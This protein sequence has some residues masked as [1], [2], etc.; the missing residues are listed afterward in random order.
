[1][2]DRSADRQ[3]RGAVLGVPELH[4]AA[5]VGRQHAQAVRQH[6]NS[7]HRATVLLNIHTYGTVQTY[8]HSPGA[9]IRDV[10]N[11]RAQGLIIRRGLSALNGKMEVIVNN[12]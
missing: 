11:S 6:H 2:S 4:D 1:M 10:H 7:R 5:G 9:D 12:E 8:A 3:A